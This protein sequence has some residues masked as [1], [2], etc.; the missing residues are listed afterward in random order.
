MGATARDMDR[1]VPPTEDERRTW[2]V[3]CKAYS[4]AGRSAGDW[5]VKPDAL[6]LDQSGLE[7]GFEWIYDWQASIPATGRRAGKVRRPGA[8]RR[9]PDDGQRRGPPYLFN[10]LT[11][12]EIAHV[13][14]S[15][16][17]RV[18]YRGAQLFSQGSPQDGIYLISKA[19]PIHGAMPPIRKGGFSPIPGRA[20]SRT[21]TW[22]RTAT[23]APHRSTHFRPTATAC[24][25]WL[26]TSGNGRLVHMTR[27]PISRHNPA[28]TRMPAMTARCGGW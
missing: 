14:G 26:A 17:R 28:A 7:F 19:R 12:Q 22:P 10:G 11:E 15:G 23:T 18:L 13:L 5:V 27:R 1:E 25:T 24:S 6:R 4:V 16:K 8:V 20:A 21:R 9:A 2:R 3:N